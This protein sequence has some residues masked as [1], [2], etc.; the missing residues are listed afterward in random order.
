MQKMLLDLLEKHK[1]NCADLLG[2]NGE[3]LT[4]DIDN[5][6]DLV[7]RLPS[8]DEIQRLRRDS[9]NYSWE[10]HPDRMGQ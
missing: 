8:D 9:I 4:I 2:N 1:N 10:R 7:K 6:I 5:L 3:L